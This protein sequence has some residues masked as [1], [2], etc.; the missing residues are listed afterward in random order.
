MFTGLKFQAGAGEQK[1]EVG[2][3]AIGIK[4]MSL[5]TILV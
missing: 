4:V 1:K 5:T 2:G 3:S